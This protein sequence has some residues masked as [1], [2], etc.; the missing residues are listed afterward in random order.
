MSLCP[1]DILPNREAKP[2][3]RCGSK[4]IMFVYWDCPDVMPVR[5]TCGNLH[6]WDE[7]HDSEEEAIEAWDERADSKYKECLDEIKRWALAKINC[8]H[9]W[10]SLAEGTY[11]EIHGR[12]ILGILEKHGL[13]EMI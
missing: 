9:S 7:W 3:P 2:C 13:K 4:T 6:T 1:L 5:C 8:D 11:E 10:C 12:S